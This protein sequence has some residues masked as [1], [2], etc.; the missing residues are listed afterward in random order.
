MKNAT[1]AK[2]FWRALYVRGKLR[3]I[4]LPVI[5]CAKIAMNPLV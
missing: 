4:D 1:G 5:S 2:A 3:V